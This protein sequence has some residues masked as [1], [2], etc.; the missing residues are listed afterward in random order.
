MRGRYFGGGSVRLLDVLDAL[1]QSVDARRAVVLA[2]L[3][4]Q[5]AAAT[6]DQILGRSPQ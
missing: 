3:A 5:L 1:T 4:S 6:Q 2:D